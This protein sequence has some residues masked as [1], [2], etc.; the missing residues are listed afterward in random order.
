MSG[1]LPTSVQARQDFHRAR[2]RAAI[3]EISARFTGKS[4]SLLSYEDVRHK[5][6]GF[7]STPRGL[8]DISLEAIVGSV[9]RYNDF[10]RD[11]LPLQDTIEERWVKVKVAVEQ[12]AGLPPIEVYQIGNVYFVRDGNH[13]VSVARQLGSTYIQAYVTEVKTRIGLTPDVKPDDLIIKAEYAEFLDKTHLDKLRPRLDLS[14]TVPGQYQV[15]EEHIEV[16]RYYM[17]IEQ[18]RYISYDKACMHWYDD[19]YLP[20]VQAINEHGILWDFP[21]RTETDLFLWI[22]EHRA[23]I[24]SE[25]GWEVKPVAVAQDL[26]SQFSSRRDRVASRLAE[27]V[28]DVVLPDELESGPPAGEWRRL[29]KESDGNNLFSDLL[30]PI[31]SDAGGWNAL[32][33]AII[34]AS[35]EGSH[36]HGLHVIP[37]EAD[38][39]A[40]EILAFQQTFREQCRIAQVSGSL[41]ITTGQISRQICSRSRWADLL[42]VN[43][44]YPPGTSPISRLSSG[45]SYLIRRCPRP[46][47]C[48]PADITPLNRALLAFDG[49]PKAHEALFLSAYLASKWEIALTVLTVRQK[50]RKSEEALIQAKTYLDNLG[51]QAAYSAKVGNVVD[52]IMQTAEDTSS[53]F[54]L[55]GGYRS[56]P[57]VE[58]TVGS[59][60]NLVLRESKLPLFICR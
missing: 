2:W 37:E 45:I 39:G 53:D 32:S 1:Q 11:F 13:R 56:S 8:Q 52:K 43:I 31:S 30:V 51:I 10:S 34:V 55:M 23:L 25:V 33:A 46:I 9:G 50:G 29:K 59:L 44:S 28:L 19:V 49:S 20:V 40:P 26:A 6:K 35:R 47:L 54:I 4:L 42:V 14:V 48:V 57:L 17:G 38:R 24:E 16:H 27:K 60:V 7:S 21:N 3:K 22:A 36:I 15:L 58:I 41:I 18:E 12:M 5:L